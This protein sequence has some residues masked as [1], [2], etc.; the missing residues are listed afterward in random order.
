MATGWQIQVNQF[1]ADAPS[2]FFWG[3]NLLWF[4]YDLLSGHPSRVNFIIEQGL[5]RPDIDRLYGK[6]AREADC[7]PF[8]VLIYDDEAG[9]RDNALETL[10]AAGW[11]NKMAKYLPEEFLKAGHRKTAACGPQPGAMATAIC[12]NG[13]AAANSLEALEDLAIGTRTRVFERYLQASC[14]NRGK[15]N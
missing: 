4:Y 7:G 11:P 5:Q 15:C 1:T 10:Q 3:S 13:A 12:A 2:L 6:P 9:L 8:H 14:A